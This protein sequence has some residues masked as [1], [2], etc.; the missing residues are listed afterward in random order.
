MKHD[1]ILAFTASSGRHGLQS[2]GKVGGV[3]RMPP[4]ANLPSLR[5]ENSGN[6]PTVSLV[7]TGGAGWGGAEK[8]EG[9]ATAGG[10]AVSGQQ[11]AASTSSQQPPAGG[12]SSMGHSVSA[13]SAFIY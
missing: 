5:S 11:A 7:P 9:A 12:Q 4:P 6:D 8:S 3:R 10:A 2:L 13:V 1:F